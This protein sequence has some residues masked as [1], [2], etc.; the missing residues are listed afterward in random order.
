MR[1]DKPSSLKCFLVSL[2]SS[3][4]LPPPPFRGEGAKWQSFVKKNKPSSLPTQS[5]LLSVCLGL[6]ADA[7][8]LCLCFGCAAPQCLRAVLGLAL[9]KRF[10]IDSI[11]FQ[12]KSNRSRR[13]FCIRLPLD[14]ITELFDQCLSKLGVSLWLFFCPIVL[15]KLFFW[16]TFMASMFRD[17]RIDMDHVACRTVGMEW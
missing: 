14:L 9:E 2:R 4:I 15:L 5:A 10:A 7:L 8:D 1:K 17:P 12:K 13:K 3:A 6:S 16:A 11:A